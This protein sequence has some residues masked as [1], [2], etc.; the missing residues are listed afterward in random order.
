MYE[1]SDQRWT[2][3]GGGAEQAL[4]NCSAKRHWDLGGRVKRE[5]QRNERENLRW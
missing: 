3:W 5:K 4:R 1:G 2:L